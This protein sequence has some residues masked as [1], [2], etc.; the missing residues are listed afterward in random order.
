MRCLIENAKVLI[1]TPPYRGLT[2]RVWR[3]WLDGMTVEVKVGR[4]LLT[5]DR[6]EVSVL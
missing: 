4:R 3:V 6:K 5:V 1:L 2:G